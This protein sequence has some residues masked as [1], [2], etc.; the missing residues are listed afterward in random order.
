MSN[1]AGAIAVLETQ[2]SEG[3]K[4]WVPLNAAGY[5]LV[6]T[7][8]LLVPGAGGLGDFQVQESVWLGNKNVLA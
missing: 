4:L 1:E 2:G 5:L 3:E 8:A 6:Q 7:S